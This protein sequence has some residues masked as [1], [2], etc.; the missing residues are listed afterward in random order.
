MQAHLESVHNQRKFAIAVLHG[1]DFA[2]DDCFRLQ[3]I[4]T[5][6]LSKCMNNEQCFECVLDAWMG[7]ASAS[8]S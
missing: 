8:S 6:L 7:T 2:L 1:P 5:K 4:Q 3:Q